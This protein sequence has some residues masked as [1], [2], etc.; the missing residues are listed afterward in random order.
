MAP[1]MALAPPLFQPPLM[2]S[3]GPPKVDEVTHGTLY[4]TEG[5]DLA[6]LWLYE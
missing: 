1:T 6:C 5:R 4:A 2:A 3:L